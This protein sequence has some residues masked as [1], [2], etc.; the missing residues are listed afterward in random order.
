MLSVT[1]EEAKLKRL[2]KNILGIES[3]KLRISVQVA[4]KVFV[5]E[6]V[7]RAIEVAAEEGH[8]SKLLPRHLQEARRRFYQAHNIE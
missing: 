6:L 3:K 8:K 2:I 5:G 4:A 1:L 7:E